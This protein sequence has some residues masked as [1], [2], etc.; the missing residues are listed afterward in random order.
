MEKRSLH[1]VHLYRVL[2]LLHSLLTMLL[3]LD[4]NAM[5]SVVLRSI[6]YHRGCLFLTCV[7]FL[8]TSKLISG[9]DITPVQTV[10]RAS[11]TRSYP[12]YP[13]VPL[14][15]SLPFLSYLTDNSLS[16]PVS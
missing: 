1:E 16:Y 13:S 5:V 3:Q 6:E 2:L 9:V 7:F 10:S 14:S 12:V 15:S 4:R 11:T 8:L